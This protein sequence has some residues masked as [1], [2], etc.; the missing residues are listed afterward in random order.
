MVTAEMTGTQYDSWV[1]R[2]REKHNL[3][4]GRQTAGPFH[5]FVALATPELIADLE[6]ADHD[7][8]RDVA[9]NPDH[10]E[11]GKPIVIFVMCYTPQN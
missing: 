2:M 11:Y 9:D 3:G 4:D 1:A 7:F 5:Q 10:P 6:Y 8:T